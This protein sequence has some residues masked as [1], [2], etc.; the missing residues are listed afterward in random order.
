MRIKN[1]VVGIK[2]EMMISILI[3][4]GKRKEFLPQKLQQTK[5]IPNTDTV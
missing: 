5:T 1:N 4:N 2:C 3:G